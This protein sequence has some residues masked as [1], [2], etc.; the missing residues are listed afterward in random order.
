MDHRTIGCCAKQPGHTAEVSEIGSAWRHDIVERFRCI[1]V[2]SLFGQRD[3]KLRPKLL[4]FLHA[5]AMNQESIKPIAECA[6]KQWSFGVAGELAGKIAGQPFVVDGGIVVKF[7]GGGAGIAKQGFGMR[8]EVD[9]DQPVCCEQARETIAGEEARM[10]T[11][12]QQG[13]LAQLA[14]NV[15]LWSATGTMLAT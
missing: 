7:E 13:E 4:R 1:G 15:A 2:G 3:A 14:T 9:V 8:N 10:G 6:A 12:R 5:I 11:G